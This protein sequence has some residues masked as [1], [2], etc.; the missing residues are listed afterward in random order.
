MLHLSAQVD[1]P[2]EISL[3]ASAASATKYASSLSDVLQASGRLDELTAMLPEPA[4]PE[5]SPKAPRRLW[6]RGRK[7]QQNLLPV[8]SSPLLRLHNQSQHPHVQQAHTRKQQQQTQQQTQTQQQQQ[9]Q[10]STI[11]SMLSHLLPTRFLSVLTAPEA[12]LGTSSS[13]SEPD[14]PASPHLYNQSIPAH[15]QSIPAVRWLD[16]TSSKSSH[17]FQPASAGIAKSATRSDRTARFTYESIASDGSGIASDAGGEPDLHR[18]GT[19]SSSKSSVQYRALRLRTP[20]QPPC[21][22][23]AQPGSASPKTR[24]ASSRARAKAAIKGFNMPACPRLQA[25]LRVRSAAVF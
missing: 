1:L 4:T 24:A 3:N 19:G 13:L 16:S 8:P 5:G 17:T 10:Q 20:E 7:Q 22:Q 12:A 23:G 11:S 21:A 6:L 14:E 9:T 15:N 25:S 2:L 18:D